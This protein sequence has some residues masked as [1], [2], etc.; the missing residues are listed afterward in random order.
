[1]TPAVMAVKK[2]QIDFSLHEYN[3]DPAA[4][5]YSMEAAEELGL[6][7]NRVYKTLLVQVSGIR[8]S[9]VVSLVPVRTMGYLV[10]GISPLG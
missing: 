8:A 1:M 9:L 3:H 7:A 6:E 4:V 5:S 2:D 10:R